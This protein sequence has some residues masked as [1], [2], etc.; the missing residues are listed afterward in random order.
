MESVFYISSY[1]TSAFLLSFGFVFAGMGGV[2]GIQKVGAW[3]MAFFFIGVTMIPLTTYLIHGVQSTYLNFVRNNSVDFGAGS[4][5]LACFLFMLFM[6]AQLMVY[7]FISPDL[8]SMKKNRLKITVSLSAI[9]WSAVPL[10]VTVIVVYLLSVTERADLLSGITQQLSP[11]LLYILIVSVLSSFAL[12]IGISLHKLTSLIFMVFPGR[13]TVRKSYFF[14]L[15]LCLLTMFTMLVFKP[16]LYAT[17]IFY[18]N[19]FVS[20]AFALWL[21]VKS[22][23]QWGIEFSLILVLFVLI[24]CWVSFAF[25]EMT[26]PIISFALSGI[27]LFV[28]FVRKVRKI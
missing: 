18:L 28:V 1:W 4:F 14:N 20:L 27:T 24:G 19:F 9:C 3:L 10:S 25:K 12:G 21:L 2:Q 15:F 26:G 22:N 23:V 11:P 13:F 17:F 6:A 8:S 5:I 7:F 16:T